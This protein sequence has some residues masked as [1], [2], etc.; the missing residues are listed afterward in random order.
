[1]IKNNHDKFLNSNYKNFLKK[2]KKTHR[3]INVNIFLSLN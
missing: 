2:I 1:M 3:K